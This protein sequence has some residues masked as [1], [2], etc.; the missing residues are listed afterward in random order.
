LLWW[1]L[2]HLGPRGVSGGEVAVSGNVEPAQLATMREE[3][4]QGEKTFRDA[5]GRGEE[6]MAAIAV[7]I[8]RQEELVRLQPDGEAEN[9]R[10]RELEVMRDTAQAQVAEG[11]IAELEAQ[12]DEARRRG[13]TD[14]ALA[15]LQEALSLQRS[16]NA[17]T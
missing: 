2:A 1:W 12:A 5:G 17:T 8:E 15:D 10:L 7:A 3:V 9:L 4:A 11:R 14:A 16:I 6:A 13:E